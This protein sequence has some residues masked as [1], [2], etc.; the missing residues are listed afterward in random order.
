VIDG[1]VF[2]ADWEDSYKQE[3]GDRSVLAILTLTLVVAI[4]SLHAQTLEGQAQSRTISSN[5]CHRAW[6][7][8]HLSMAKPSMA[9]LQILLLHVSLVVF[10]VTS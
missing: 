1:E 6:N 3:C 4:G 10:Y 9:T 7:L 8:L 2:Q 5:L